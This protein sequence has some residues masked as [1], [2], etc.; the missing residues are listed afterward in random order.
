MTEDY[1]RR[2]IASLSKDKAAL[3][4]KQSAAL[5]KAATLEADA[6]QADAGITKHTSASSARQKLKSAADKRKRAASERERAAKCVKDAARKGDDVASAQKSLEREVER[7]LKKESDEA[8]KAQRRAKDERRSQ[9]RFDRTRRD[10]ELRH[11][12]ELARHAERSALRFHTPAS[13]PPPQ[14]RVLLLAASPSDQEPLRL[15]QEIRDI[16]LNVRMS[17]YRDRLDLQ[18]RLAV[19]TGDL[20]QALNEVNPHVVHFSGHGSQDILI[21][22]D[23]HGNSKPMN[24]DALAALL[25]AT[26][27]QV[28]LVIFNSCSSGE[29]A[30]L[31]TQ[32]VEMAIGMDVSIDD[33]AAKEFAV[34]F[35][36]AIGFGL[37]VQDAFEQAKAAIA[38]ADFHGGGTPILH[39]AEGV[40]PGSVYL[41]AG[42]MR[43]AA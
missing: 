14:L 8:R 23:D 26:S 22:E 5:S 9:D 3:E 21:F 6:H 42:E 31:A 7:R 30:V 24:N 13:P 28:R 12:R 36:S 11:A 20:L 32:H 19:R 43:G 29:Q 37:S 34:Q 41:I 33:R 27:D 16:R 39:A 15:H 25:N 1:Y 38:I 17:E 35:Y 10:E 18:D 2:R 40:N 4:G